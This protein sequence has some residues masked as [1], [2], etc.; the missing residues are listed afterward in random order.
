MTSHSASR[1]EHDDRQIPF[2]ALLL[3]AAGV[4][5]FVALT[6]AAL[7]RVEERF[8]LPPGFARAGLVGYGV[9]IVS[10]LG[11]IRWGAGLFHGDAKR[12]AALFA[13]SVLAPLVAWAALF[14]PR[15]HDLVVLIGCFLILGVSDVLLASRGAA[16]RWYGT[17]RGVL[18][19]AVVAVLIFA[20]AMLPLAEFS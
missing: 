7:L 10:F 2:P 5:P 11:G 18:T 15:P 6:L 12:A 4:L 1:H 17:L 19:V 14:M 20:L 3:G 8:G 16:P 13:L 9:V